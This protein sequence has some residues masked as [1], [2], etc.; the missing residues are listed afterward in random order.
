MGVVYEAVDTRLGRTV[1]LKM[2]L[3]GAHASERERMRFR[4]EAETVA[5]LQHSGIVQI[6]DI[7]D[8]AAG[9]YLALEFVPGG[10]LAERLDGKPWLAD[11]A[12]RFIEQLA[13]ALQAAHDAGVI[14]RDLKPGNILLV[15]SG[16]VSGELSETATHHSLLTAHQTT[17][18]QPKIADFGLAK[19]F[20][21]NQGQTVSG[22]IV[23][24]PN[25][26]APE[27]A[28]GTGKQ[29]GPHTDVYA[30]GAI[31]YE[32]LTGRPPFQG[33]TMVETL[34]QVRRLEPVSVRQLQ[35]KVPKDI[36]TICHKCLQKDARKRY[37]TARALGD[38]LRRFLERRP[39]TA[40]PVGP[41]ERG[42]RWCRRNP[43]V[44]SLL[45][46]VGLS[47]L[48]GTIVATY[49]ALE[50]HQQAA[51]AKRN[52]REANEARARADRNLYAA[53]IN[54]AQNALRDY[55]PARLRDL[56]EES[57]PQGDAADLRG[58]EWHFL[59]RQVRMEH[60]AISY[61]SP[62]G[63]NLS[64]MS[65]HLAPMAGRV[66]YLLPAEQPGASSGPR[67]VEVSV[68]DVD[69]GRVVFTQRSSGGKEA[70]L[71][72][73]LSSDGRWLATLTNERVTLW[74]VDSG[75]EVRSLPF[76]L[77][78]AAAV[79]V[80]GKR[81][82]VGA[83][84]GSVEVFD[85]ESGNS[86]VRVPAPKPE[87]S[88]SGIE[89][90]PDG[91][92][93]AI[94]RIELRPPYNF[95]VRV[96]IHD[97]ADGRERLAVGPFTDVEALRP[98]AFGSNGRRVGVQVSRGEIHVWETSGFRFRREGAVTTGAPG[99]INAFAISSDGLYVAVGLWNGLISV[100]G[101]SGVESPLYLRGHHSAVGAIGFRRA[102]GLCSIAN[103]GTLR[104]WE[105][106]RP[107]VRRLPGRSGYLIGSTTRP[108]FDAKGRLLAEIVSVPGTLPGLPTQ[109]LL[110]WETETGS[111]RLRKSLG[112]MPADQVFASGLA[113]TG[114]V[115]LSPNGNRVAYF[116]NPRP[117]LDAIKAAAGALPGVTTRL[118]LGPGTGVPRALLDAGISAVTP[119]ADVVRVIDIR[120]RAERY[121]F[122]ASPDIR[123]FTFS[124]DG[125]HLLVA[126]R[127]WE[128]HDV[129]ART[130]RLVVAASLDETYGGAFHPSGQRFA[131]A[132]SGHRAPDGPV[133]QPSATITL[134][135]LDARDSTSVPLSSEQG[136]LQF[137][138]LA[139]SPDG[140]HLLAVAS[141]QPGAPPGTEA[142]EG[143]LD[144]LVW[145]VE[146]RDAPEPVL[147]APLGGGLWL[148]A[149]EPVVVAFSDDGTLL[150]AA[151]R[152]Q[153]EQAEIHVWDL[154][155]GRERYSFRSVAGEVAFLAFTPDGK[156]LLAAGSPG[157]GAGD[158][159]AEARIWDL[160][161]G[162]ELL[163]IP[164]GSVIASQTLGTTAF[165]F[166]GQRLRAVG[167]NDKGGELRLL[168]GTPESSPSRSEPSPNGVGK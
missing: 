113:P 54:L 34:E 93:L 51:D 141:R 152:A 86:E 89:F 21:S 40:R 35:P 44:A 36:E 159:T 127:G 16:V 67:G 114:R 96:T 46:L 161:T 57:Q 68:R 132:H 33:A 39:I 110:V 123:T 160:T 13:D 98:V 1:A 27:Q 101:V 38:D 131:I 136:A 7:G 105:L 75:R 137:E 124:P 41:L 145:R 17:T 84:D 94:T 65:V 126:G 56:L 64:P 162:Q 78:R 108:S 100:V 72:V 130:R 31:L 81:F 155:A 55:R 121:A 95:L 28:E 91:R 62:G 134:H 11:P 79:G 117:G 29:V 92:L 30:L 133:P 163:E 59:M 165:H 139:F 73:N 146:E 115:L 119:E 102:E 88:V 61:G 53:R 3:V 82:A 111:Q 74:D 143:A 87:Q 122:P 109:E 12:A 148:D 47:L 77:P 154:A 14:H 20:D 63:M 116:L 166:D 144:L 52:A 99:Q 129:E 24:T 6:H 4:Q 97:A 157:Y 158:R 150:A 156:R 118:G 149:H 49:F 168:D 8:C 26:M 2:I 23:G 120:N 147:E 135:S 83:M 138:R 25:Y 22:A 104:Q 60:S 167:W 37:P 128:L 58:W 125:R 32:L 42:W 43:A 66:A 153:G 90:S 48:A 85:A 106:R 164:L 76:E 80:R 151:A 10:S 5:R 50:A 103:D 45:V 18:H 70:L 140:R 142:R 9:P 71:G 107:E 15:S 112:V 19:R 69:S